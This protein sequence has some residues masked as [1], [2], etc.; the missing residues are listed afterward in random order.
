M[1]KNKERNSSYYNQAYSTS[2]AYYKLPE[3]IPEYYE[4]WLSAANHVISHNPE[5]VVDLGCGAGHF[6]EILKRCYI[7]KKINLNKYYG[8]DFSS[9][10]LDM[11]NKMVKNPLFIFEKQDLYTFDFSHKKPKDTLYVSYEFLEHINGDI[12]VLEKIPSGSTI[13]FSVPSFD[14]KGHVRFFKSKKEIYN[15]Y[16]SVI[17]IKNIQVFIKK[18]KSSNDKLFLFLC[19]GVKR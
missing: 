2:K 1:K 14:S 10:A 9:V 6:A 3:E 16:N 17:D 11:A 8:Y 15:R 12:E 5:V 7:D 4:M 13:S 18:Q 19:L